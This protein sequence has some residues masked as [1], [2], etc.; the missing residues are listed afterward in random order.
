MPPKLR[1]RSAWRIDRRI[2]DG[3]HI[4]AD[5]S[6]E[7][8]RDACHVGHSP[9]MAATIYKQVLQTLVVVDWSLLSNGCLIE[10]FVRVKTGVL[11]YLLCGSP[12][13]EVS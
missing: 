6:I 5:T 3:F 12:H 7:S 2:P 13:R 10:R 4:D 11:L 9:S 1:A 8:S